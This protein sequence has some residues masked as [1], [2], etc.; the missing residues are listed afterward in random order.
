MNEPSSAW[1]EGSAAASEALPGTS[2][3][4]PSSGNCEWSSCCTIVVPPSAAIRYEASGQ[5]TLPVRIPS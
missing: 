1:A 3:K 2:L 5:V 4:Q